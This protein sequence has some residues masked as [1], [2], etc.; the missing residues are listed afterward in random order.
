MA[1]SLK[2]VLPMQCENLMR[3]S[4]KGAVGSPRE[5]KNHGSHHTI[6]HGSERIHLPGSCAYA[7]EVHSS[8]TGVGGG[9]SVAT[10]S[11]TKSPSPRPVTVPSN[12]HAGG[13]DVGLRIRSPVAGPAPK[14]EWAFRARCVIVAKRLG[15][16]SERGLD[17]HAVSKVKAV[18][19]KSSACSSVDN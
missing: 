12:I 10:G 11:V 5:K 16:G 1:R 4:D 6:V 7:A 19:D 17:L 2:M 14:G 15:C 9:W 18:R 3:L 8:C 13:T